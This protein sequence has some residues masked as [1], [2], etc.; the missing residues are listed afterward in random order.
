ML[1]TH[2]PGNLIYFLTFNG[3]FR[4]M[5][6][7]LSF[8]FGILLLAACGGKTSSSGTDK[9]G[10]TT[11]APS[12]KIE[13]QLP[14]NW[15]AHNLGE[16]GMDLQV[17]ASDSVSI[18]TFTYMNDAGS[19]DAINV[20]LSDASSLKFSIARTTANFESYYTKLKS[21]PFDKL[22]RELDKR[23][24]ALFYEYEDNKGDIYYGML[25]VLSKNQTSYVMESDNMM[26]PVKDQKAAETL[27]SMALS[28]K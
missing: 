17:T 26:N 25:V 23:D 22:T 27:Y 18:Y 13:T 7:I 11:S 2:K 24:N 12:E 4:F 20:Q 3:K 15:T 6:K 16:W 10:K 21:S 1:R 28:V 19:Q 14:G 9:T 5:K 8:S